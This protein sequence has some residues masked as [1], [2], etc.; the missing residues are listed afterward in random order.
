MAINP[1]YIMLCG[2]SGSGKTTLRKEIVAAM[3]VAILATDD[4]IEMV[5]ATTGRTYTE[6]FEPCIKTAEKLMNGCREYALNNRLN[7]IHDQTNLSV[8]SRTKKLSGIPACYTKVCLFLVS[9]GP[10]QLAQRL[11]ERPGKVIGHNVVE[12]QRLTWVSPTS[13]EGFDIIVPGSMWRDVL[14]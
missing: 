1:V 4:Y 5:A 11:A 13:E 3:D 6:M 8:K 10:N 7:I 2:V 9:P 14:L 12:S